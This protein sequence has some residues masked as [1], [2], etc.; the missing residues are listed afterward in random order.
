MV[1]AC[2]VIYILE[3]SLKCSCHSRDLPALVLGVQQAH[4]LHCAQ[5]ALMAASLQLCMHSAQIRPPPC[6]QS[7]V[8]MYKLPLRA[9]LGGQSSGCSVQLAHAGARHSQYTERNAKVVYSKRTRGKPYQCV[10]AQQVHYR[11]AE[12]QPTGWPSRQYR[13]CILCLLAMKLRW[14]HN[15]SFS[16]G[17]AQNARSGR[18]LPQQG[19]P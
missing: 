16:W 9:Y 18:G 7:R 4:T 19:V 6:G 11:L 1:A 3:V 2:S 10:E 5:A 13:L 15:M 12:P 17:L 14:H 8:Y